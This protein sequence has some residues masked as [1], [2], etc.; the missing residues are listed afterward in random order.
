MLVA[1]GTAYDRLSGNTIHV[2][3]LRKAM[4]DAADVG[5]VWSSEVLSLLDEVE[6]RHNVTWL[7]MD[8]V[9]TTGA[10]IWRLKHTTENV[11]DT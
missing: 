10:T 6:S 11:E 7:P 9:D 2:P 5:V 4:N 8:I 3:S 1:K